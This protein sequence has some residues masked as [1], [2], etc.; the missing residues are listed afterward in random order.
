MCSTPSEYITPEVF[1]CNALPLQNVIN[2]FTQLAADARCSFLGNVTVGKD[3]SLVELRSRYDAVVLA[4]GAESDK[5]L[6][7]PGEV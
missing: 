6:G 1:K 4:Y 2:H 7:V 3:V 5:R